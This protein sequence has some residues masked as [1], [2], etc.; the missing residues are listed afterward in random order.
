MPN[1]STRLGTGDVVFFNF[2][3][4]FAAACVIPNFFSE[5]MWVQQRDQWD[6][7][8]RLRDCKRLFIYCELVRRFRLK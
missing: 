8:K 1:D 2:Y 7:T 5:R 3:I 4:F 6:Y